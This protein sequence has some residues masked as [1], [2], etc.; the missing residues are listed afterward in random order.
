MK[1]AK[2]FSR[3]FAGLGTVLLLGSVLLCLFSLKAEPRV[4]A[5]PE[6]AVLCS[7]M[8]GDAV[9]ARDYGALESCIYGQP[10]LG[11]EGTPE[12]ALTAMVWE[13][14][15]ANLQLTWQGECYVKDSAFL[16]DASVTYMDISPIL[17]NLP[18]RAHALLTQRVEAA[19]SMEELYDGSGEF[20]QELLDEVM[21]A[22][23]TQCCM[24]DARTVT[25]DITVELIS[26]DGQWWA[27]PDRQLLTA[28]SG[29]AA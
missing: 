22:A 5:L 3:I 16:R 15:Q 2:V 13:L 7:E 27:V 21:K 25:A 29:G 6:G 11:L 23:M 17:E 24:E 12:E 18:A 10:K 20:R 1:I 8:L 26:R 28:L 19:Q 4:E 14:A 9:A